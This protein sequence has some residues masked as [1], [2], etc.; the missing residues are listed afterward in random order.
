VWRKRRKAL[1]DY[2]PKELDNELLSGLF[3]GL[4]AKLKMVTEERIIRQ[5]HVMALYTILLETDVNDTLP[6]EL[7]AQRAKDANDFSLS[8]NRLR[9]LHAALV[10]ELSAIKSVRNHRV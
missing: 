2:Q 5:Q 6:R 8:L 3:A 10:E 9:N 4:V 7:K 1:I